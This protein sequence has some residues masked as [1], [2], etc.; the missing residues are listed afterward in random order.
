LLEN[1]LYYFDQELEGKK[2]QPFL[3]KRY[4]SISRETEKVYFKTFVTG[5]I[6]KHNVFAKGF[7]I[8][9]HREFAVPVLKIIIRKDGSKRIQLVFEYGPYRFTGIPVNHVS[10][11][12][13]YKEEE[14]EYVFHRMRRSIAWEEKQVESLK[15]LGLENIDQF[16]AEY[17]LK[18][19]VS[20]NFSSI[21][22]WVN[23]HYEALKAK[24]F[25]I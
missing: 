18:A 12:L 21:Y 25:V 9:T 22:A 11:K 3:N 2:L 4:I 20:Q 7:E 8:K 1:V 15:D 14:D 24:N 6:E 5:L 17:V 16:S 10:V 13:E 19:E 23:H